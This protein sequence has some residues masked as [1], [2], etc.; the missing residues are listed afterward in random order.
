MHTRAPFHPAT[1]TTTM[2]G[3]KKSLINIQSNDIC[4]SV[5]VAKTVSRLFLPSSSQAQKPF[6]Y[7]YRTNARVA[8]GLISH[9]FNT[10]DFFGCFCSKYNFVCI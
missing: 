1:R 9:L 5:S 3:K 10:M 7:Y 4:V 8:N 6:E 2:A